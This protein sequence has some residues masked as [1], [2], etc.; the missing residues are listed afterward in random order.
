MIHLTKNAGTS[1]IFE[2][3]ETANQ[4]SRNSNYKVGKHNPFIGRTIKSEK[5]FYQLRFLSIENIIILVQ[6]SSIYEEIARNSLDKESIEISFILLSEVG[7]KDT[8]QIKEI[9]GSS[10]NNNAH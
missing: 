4:Y 6:L 3:Q 9:S 5:I 1:C 10:V 8:V 7:C 2:I